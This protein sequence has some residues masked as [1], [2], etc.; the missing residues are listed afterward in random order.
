MYHEIH[1]LKREGF[2]PC[3][4]GLKLGLDRRTIKKYLAM[5]EEEF[6]DF[7]H[8]QQTRKKLLDKY[9]D[10]VRNRLEDCPEA[11]AAQVHDWLKE[12]FDDIIK[13]NEKTVFNYVLSIRNKYGIPKPFNYRDYAQV[14]E[15]PFGKQ[16][17]VDFGEY[18]MTTEYGKRKKVY[19][20]SMVL[21]R[22]RQKYV[23]FRDSPFTTL[24]AIDAHEKCF[25][26]FEGIPAE[27]VYDQDKLFL[28][29]ENKG[30]LMLTDEFRNYV[31]HRGFKSHFCRKADPQSKGKIENVVKYIKYNFLRGRKY[32]DVAILNGQAYQWLNRTAN[33]KIH[34]STKKT[35]GQ[36]W[37]TEK[38]YLKP[39]SDLFKTQQIVHS[40]SVRKDNTIV[41]KSNFYR[42][43][44]GTYKGEGTTVNV[45]FTDEDILI[46]DLSDNEIARY[47]I[48]TGK[49]KLVGNNN[50]KRDYSLKIDQLITKTSAMFNNTDTAKD[51]FQQVRSDN[52]R[53]IRDQLLMIKK[54]IE[55][56]GMDVMEQALQF[57]IEN[58]ILKASDME[59]FAK[60][61]N[62]ENQTIQTQAQETI[63]VRTLNKSVFKIVPQ[64]SDIS[65][66]KN[67]M[68]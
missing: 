56:Y 3:R 44:L 25:R 52:P 1:R 60:N 24:A 16:A 47:K 20:F 46:Y 21:S 30:N 63:K 14:E 66:Y 23:V 12:N 55:K 36:E 39:I 35:P 38:E 18:N 15:L 27:L 11:S 61:I 13:V 42:V 53:Y 67:V 33:A 65:D 59:S 45:K 5:S 62:V 7:K 6:L 8:R 9:E 50:F 49:G 31:L 19:F 10:Y 4:I 2:K 32:I 43:P 58:K 51:Y 48:F 26:F 57:C 28:I 41:Y 29:D 22:S 68:N 40:Y 54:M 34:S 64:K 17:Q 37:M